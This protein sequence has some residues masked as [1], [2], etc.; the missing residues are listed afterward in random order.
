[1]KKRIRIAVLMGGKTPEHEISLVSGREITRNLPEKYEVLPIVISRTGEKWSLT[2]RS[3]LLSLPDP[4]ILKGTQK[5]FDS[6]AL[7]EIESV[8]G[9]FKKVDIVF[10]AMHGPF[11]EDG[12]IQ[13]ML[14][15]AGVPFTGPG[16]LASALGMN[17]VL[18]RKILKSQ[19]LP[20]PKFVVVEKGEKGSS[21]FKELG[22]PPYVVKPDNQGS[23]VG[24]SLV[25]SKSYL[26]KALKKAFKFSDIV[27]VDEYVEG[28]E[29]TCGI[30]GNKNPKPLPLVEILPKKGDFFNYESKYME[31]GAVEI[32]PA[33]ISKTLTKKIQGMATEVY[34]AL[35]CKG[36]SRVDFILRRERYPVI[37]EINTIPG[38]TPMSL[39]P[40]AA[41]AEGLSY[42]QVLDKIIKYGLEK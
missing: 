12:T 11:G 6:P 38:L 17:K 14:E 28:L 1:M 27:L 4:M 2:S 34:K 32:V 42:S 33:R 41:R 30:L 26:S 40:K 13:G 9:I 29:V 36:F 37:L 22:A 18:F 23:S 24:I 19:G 21:V 39:F 3:Q 31:G 15:L 8:G 16:V 35:G 10:I 25:N 5:E 7:K 20:F